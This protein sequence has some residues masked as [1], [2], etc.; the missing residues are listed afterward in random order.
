MLFVGTILTAT[1]DS[2][3]LDDD[4]FSDPFFDDSRRRREKSSQ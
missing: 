4:A 2:R 1:A 3:L